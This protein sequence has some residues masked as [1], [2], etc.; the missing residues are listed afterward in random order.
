MLTIEDQ[1]TH[2]TDRYGLSGKRCFAYKCTICETETPVPHAGLMEAAKYAGFNGD[3]LRWDGSFENQ[4]E[5][6][7]VWCEPMWH[8]D[9]RYDCTHRSFAVAQQILE[10]L[11]YSNPEG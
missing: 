11:A 7:S 6:K 9:L 3:A 1:K 8:E 4:E 5:F 10:S 2:Y